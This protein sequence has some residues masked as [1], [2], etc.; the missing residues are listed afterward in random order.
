MLVLKGIKLRVYPNREQRAQIQAS[1]G[2]NRFVWNQML[3]MLITR[4][5]N[6]PELSLPSSYTLDYLLPQVKA[7][8][9]LFEICR[10]YKF[11]SHKS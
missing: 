6:N 3:N 1:F 11:P 5:E 9:S 4:Y 10:K 7:R 8:I 2:C